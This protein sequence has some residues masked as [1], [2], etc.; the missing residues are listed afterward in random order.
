MKHRDLLGALPILAQCLGRKLGVRVVVGA[1][2]ARTDGKTIFLPSLPAENP[3][4]A[5]LANGFLDHEAAHIRHTDFAV[6]QELPTP[7]G[8]ALLNVLEDVRIE[9]LLGVAFPGSNHNLADLVR[10][11]VRHEGFGELPRDAAPAA[12]LLGFLLTRLRAEVLGQEAL[13]ASADR[14]ERELRMRL[15]PGVMA[16]L[17]VLAREGVQ[18]ASTAEVVATVQRILTML[19]EDATLPPA[20]GVDRAEPAKDGADAIPSPATGEGPPGGADDTGPS[21]ES[22]P[23]PGGAGSDAAAV[24]R[25]H[26][27]L[28]TDADALSAGHLDLGAR[29]GAALAQAAGREG[30]RE[31][32]IAMAECDPLPNPRAGAARLQRVRAATVSLRRRLSGLVQAA[33][34]DATWRSSAGRRLLPRELY[35]LGLGEGGV[36][37]KSTRVEAAN[38]VLYLLLDRSD[39]MRHEMSVALDA[40]LAIAVALA[41]IP[42]VRMAASAFPGSEETRIL[43]LVR[44]D[45]R[46]VQVAGRFYLSGQGGTPMLEALWRAGFELLAQPEPRKLCLV[47]TDGWP[48]DPKG[49]RAFIQRAR[50][51]GIEV[52][53]LGIGEAAQ[54]GEL[55]GRFDAVSIQGIEELAP[56]LFRLLERRLTQTLAA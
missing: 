35:R 37:S 38:T 36:F 50:T 22:P 7:L 53:G 3:A 13:A 27:L 34:E 12:V 33:R 21:A 20:S 42:G 6:L 28:A 56:A 16:R 31:G 51:S 48:N 4:V 17:N 23:A 14:H 1:A 19:A 54:V 44:F 45:E 55:F 11:L 46:P 52:L 24:T 15:S 9:R 18:G 10:H 39:S 25:I 30:G 26:D 49:V 43:P 41:E 5:V 47:V 8:K 29:A 40:T 2:G 32:G